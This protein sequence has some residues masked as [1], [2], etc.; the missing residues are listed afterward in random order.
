MVGRTLST[1]L[2]ESWFGGGTQRGRG[3]T[4]AE[5]GAGARS[6]QAIMLDVHCMLSSGLAAARNLAGWLGIDRILREGDS[7]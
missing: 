3:D 4:R 1:G 6:Q 5:D 7:R 2:Y